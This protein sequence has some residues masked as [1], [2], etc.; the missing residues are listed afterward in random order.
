MR[1]YWRVP[2]FSQ[3]RESSKIEQPAA[4]A[5]AS[6]LPNCRIWLH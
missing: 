3:K 2:D 6:H 1:G 4:A 5:N